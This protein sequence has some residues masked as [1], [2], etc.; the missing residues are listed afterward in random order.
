MA[1]SAWSR[2]RRHSGFDGRFGISR[3]HVLGISMG[4][5][6][7]Q[8]LALDYLEKVG[9]VR[10]PFRKPRVLLPGNEFSPDYASL[11]PECRHQGKGG[12][13]KERNVAGGKE[14]HRCKETDHN[15][16]ED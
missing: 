3:A 4:G 13:R 6:I 7:E 15:C 2:R 1:V 11:V 14:R 12:N 10:G 9:K 5:M 16:K 8:E